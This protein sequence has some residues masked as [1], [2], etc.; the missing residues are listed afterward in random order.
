MP[1]DVYVKIDPN[2]P[3]SFG[4]AITHPFKPIAASG[5]LAS[6]GYTLDDINQEF[7]KLD[8][9]FVEKL[10]FIASS[11]DVSIGASPGLTTEIVY[12]GIV[13]H[14]HVLAGVSWSYDA[15]PTT[16]NIKIKDGTSVIYDL[17]ITAAG[18]G[19]Q[20][21]DPPKQGSVGSS[22]TITLA[23]G[24]GSATGQLSASHDIR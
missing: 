15:T 18:P 1:N 7:D 14:R 4:N 8:Y 2:R 9:R 17:D 6:V 22:M 13:G 23:S 21:F 12:S 20:Y 24:A 5:S 16:G 19:F 10:N 3:I 11:G